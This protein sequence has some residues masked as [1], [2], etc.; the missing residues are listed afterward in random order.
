MPTTDSA[1]PGARQGLLALSPIL[2]FAALYLGVSLAAADFYAMP[3]S[4]AFVAASV[5]A[6]AIGRSHGTLAERI[7][8]FSRAAGSENILGMVWIFILAGAFASLASGIGAIEAT[9]NLALRYLPCEFM[10]PG[11]FI[12]ACFI[13]LSI[14]TS[15]GTVVALTPLAVEIASE[16]GV[17]TALL[18]ATLLGGA[19]FGDNLSFISDTTIAATRSQGVPMNAKFKANLA[20]VLPA[21]VATLALYV[22][23]AGG[24]DDFT[25]ATES[26]YLLV[27]PYMIVIA[28][29]ILGINV[30]IVLVSGIAAA[31]VLGVVSGTSPGAMARAMGDGIEGMGSLIVVTLL[32]A[33]MLGLIKAY[34]GISWLLAAMTRHVRG[35]RGAK[36]TMLMLVGVVN[37]CTANNTVAIITV[38]SISR[39]IADRFGIPAARAASILDTGSCIV[40]CL[41]PYGAQTLLA[42]G[43]AGISPAAPWPYLYYPWALLLCVGA[44]ILLRRD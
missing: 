12:A 27:I 28:M 19:F 23:V 38:G 9:V 7:G 17:D 29:A 6:V 8:L 11:L 3:L 20:I 16:S 14:G 32:A 21:A 15:V 44:T 2:L 25:P 4:L 43:L 22:F 35:S 31:L 5:W 18:V 26:N 37:F 41:I 34:G 39:S 42:T 13:S 40:Q 33:G 36:A 24:I 10:V 30:N 1:A